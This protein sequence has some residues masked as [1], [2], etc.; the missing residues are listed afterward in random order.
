MVA[1]FAVWTLLVWVGRLRNVAGDDELSVAGK[2]VRSGQ[3]VIFLTVVVVVAAHLARSWR[4]GGSTGSLRASVVFLSWLTIAT[5][6]VRG[7]GIVVDG[8]HDTPF[9]VVHTALALVSIGWA[10]AAQRA[11]RPLAEVAESS[12]S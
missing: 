2:W 11:V 5:W 12:P 8:D 6:L 9:K 4:G 7:T 10:V 3:A 1:G